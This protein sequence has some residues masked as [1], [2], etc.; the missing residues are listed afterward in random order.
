MFNAT[1][2]LGQVLVQTTDNRE[3][4]VEEIADRAINRMV[5]ADSKEAL[6]YWLVKY[7]QEAQEA[8]RQSICKKLNQQGYAEIAQ[9][10]G[11]L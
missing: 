9:L 2:E 1:A 8:E 4:T 7:L 11:D 5:R 10:I 3:H 6:H